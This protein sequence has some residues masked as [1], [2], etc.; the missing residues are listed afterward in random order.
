VAEIAGYLKCTKQ[1]VWALI[2]GRGNSPKLP[3][4]KIGKSYRVY[5]SEFEAF[6]NDQKIER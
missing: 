6:V 5:Q 4:V 2:R 1:R 3:A